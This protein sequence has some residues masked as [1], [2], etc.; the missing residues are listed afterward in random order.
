MAREKRRDDDSARCNVT[1]A[2]VHI[3]MY[4][5]LYGLSVVIGA[6]ARGGR[7]SQGRPSS[8]CISLSSFL[9]YFHCQSHA[10]LN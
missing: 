10:V 2:V 8:T 5:R 3:D 1:A 4:T 9:L 6:L 7:R